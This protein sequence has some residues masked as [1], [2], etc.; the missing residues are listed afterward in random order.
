MAVQW[1]NERQV[2]HVSI[3]P[4]STGLDQAQLELVQR[5]LVARRV[6]RGEFVCRAGS[7]AGYWYG[8]EDG[9]V[10]MSTIAFD[11]KEHSFIG[12][13]SGGWFGEGTLLK[14]EPRRYDIVAL[15]DTK[16][17][18]LPREVFLSLVNDSP[19]FTR[20]LLHHV[21]ERLSQF[22]ALLVNHRMSSNDARI[23][24]T[25]AWLFN[26]QLYPGMPR[27]LPIT[28]DEIARLAGFSRSRTNEAL[29]RLAA[30]RLIRI[31]YGHVTLLNIEALR[32]YEPP[33][34]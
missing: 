9:L 11:G 32:N 33:P 2:E 26:P 23:A 8:V 24:H 21:N 13:A 30:A 7:E 29:R 28:Q 34:A 6:E 1:S 19:S 4:V 17:Q 10:K 25:L 18:M 5:S 14:T 31:G 20:W 12:I 27:D 15:R 16:L 3:W 22:V